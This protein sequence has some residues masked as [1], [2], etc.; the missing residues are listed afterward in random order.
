MSSIYNL[1]NCTV[2]AVDTTIPQTKANPIPICSEAK[3]TFNCNADWLSRI[4]GY[5]IESFNINPVGGGF[6][7]QSYRITFTTSQ[8]NVDQTSLFVK[9]IILENDRPFFARVLAYL[10][11]MSFEMFSKKEVFFYNHLY[12]SFN[13]HGIQTPR[14]LYVELEGSVPMLLDIMGFQSDFRGVICLEDLGKCENISIGNLVP[15]KYASASL[16]KL[17]QLHALNWYQQ[18]HPDFPSEFIPD[19][20]I[21]FFNLNESLLNK[22]KN[23]KDTIQAL[24]WRKDDCAFLNKPQIREALITFSEH[25]DILSK[26]C[27]ND[28]LSSGPLFQH[29]TFLHGDF[30]C[31]N[32]LFKTEPSPDDS[33]SKEIKETFLIDWQC[34]GYGHPSTEFSYFLAN[35]DFDAERD[36]KLMK[37]YYEELTKTVKPE[38]YPWEVFQREVEIRNIQLAITGFNTMFSVAPEDLKKWKFLFEKRG[39]DID[40]FFKSFQPKFKRFAHI[41]EKWI[42]ENILS[43]IEEF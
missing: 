5:P 24:Y 40:F 14:P 2:D 17:A 26:Y 36:L 33:E 10:V 19:A 30:H 28:K 21:Q 31:G 6:S 23:K 11:N 37:I 16:T 43:S 20:Y 9:Y 4:L 41:M 39:M 15:E 34:F 8:K 1:L 38:E 42:Q 35:V 18:I 32:I 12:K 27:T 22:S 25:K 13:N 7:T 3:E 29:R